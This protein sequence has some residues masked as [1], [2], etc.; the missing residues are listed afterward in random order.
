MMSA[1]IGAHQGHSDTPP[2]KDGPFEPWHGVEHGSENSHGKPGGAHT[3]PVRLAPPWRAAD[4]R[5]RRLVPLCCRLVNEDFHFTGER[6]LPGEPEWAWCFQAHKFGYDDLAARLPAGA[7]VLDIG[8]GEGYGAELLARTASM[9]VAT[10]YAQEPVAHAKAKYE[11]VNMAWAACDAQRLPFA[12]R[13]FDVVCSLQVI[14]H[15]E[16]TG[17]HLRD[18]ARVLKPMGWYYV[19]TPNIALASEAE[20]NNPYHL[21]DFTAGDLQ[22]ALE[23]HFETVELLGMF[24]VESSYRVA[25]MRAAEGN[26]AVSGPKI[27]RAERLLAK[28]PGPLRVRARPLVRRLAGAP[29]ITADEARNA[30]LAEDFQARPPADESFCLIGIARGPRQ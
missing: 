26:D 1:P 2:G 16:D 10:D 25:L 14:E 30:I 7:G 13:S 20:R 23:D 29:R 17:S 3:A 18:V 9:V 22:T 15:F 21:R 28:L 4:P 12:D 24:Y 5:G 8:C 11:R 19:A 27:A 6:V